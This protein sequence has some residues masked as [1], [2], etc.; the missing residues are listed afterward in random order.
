[1]VDFPFPSAGE[2]GSSGTPQRSALQRP[3][4]LP[5]RRISL[6][7]APSMIKRHS[8]ASMVSF[9]S[10]PEEG[11]PSAPGAMMPLV[12][13]NAA[14]KSKARP[15]ALE[16][17]RRRSNWKLRPIDEAREAKRRKIVNE[18]FETERTYVDGLDLIYA[19]RLLFQVY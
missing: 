11:A 5:F 15:V 1:M 12:M 8:V 6:P 7:T 17:E 14:R 3:Q 18:F 2:P 9:E 19:V 4:Y 10:M 16:P 13:K